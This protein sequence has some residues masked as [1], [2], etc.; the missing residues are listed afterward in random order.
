MSG[1]NFAAFA[2]VVQRDRG[3]ELGDR[4]TGDTAESDHL[5]LCRCSSAGQAKFG[6][7]RKNYEV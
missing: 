1:Q 4:N 6:L 2:G 5:R 3:K 7:S